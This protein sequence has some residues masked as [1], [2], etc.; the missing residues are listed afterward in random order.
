M[1]LARK[2]LF[3]IPI[4]AVLLVLDLGMA[5]DESASEKQQ[6]P[7][8]VLQNAT[9]HTMTGKG[10]FIGS[11]I[12]EDGK[13]KSVGKTVEIP[14]GAKVLDLKGHHI[15]PGLIETRSKLWL[16]SAATTET[17]T[18]ATLDVVDAIDP[19]SEDW[20]ELASQGITSVY[21]QPSSD[22]FLGGYGAVLRVGPFDSPEGIVLK[23]QVAIQASIGSKGATSKDRF[24]QVQSLEKLFESAKEK[25]K[26]E[27]SG[28]KKDAT[29]KAT[30]PNKDAE[31]ESAEGANDNDEKKDAKSDAEKKDEKE[32]PET[33]PTKL[34]LRRVLNKEIPLHIEIHH[35]DVL[36]Q[37][38]ALAEKLD[39]LIVLDGL[40]HVESLSDQ[41]KESG[42]PLVV[43]PMY[44]PGPVPDYRKQANF[45]W[46]A[47]V[48]DSG[49]LW[50]LSSFGTSGRS[51]RL[52]RA[53][54]AVAIRTGLDHQRV[55]ASVTSNPARMLG[56]VDQIG[57]L[58]TGKSADI[59]V[60]AGD[61][62]DPCTATRLVMSQGMITFENESLPME[63]ATTQAIALPQRLPAEYAIKSSR[64]LKDG[65]FVDGVLHINDG[66]IVSMAKN[67]KLEKIQ[68]FDL[69]DTIVTPGLVIA[70]STLGQSDSISDPTE[71]DASHLRS[72]DAV[73]PTSETA[74]KALAGGFIHVGLSPGTS[75]TSAGVVGH[76]RLG[77]V[78]Y[79]AEPA[80]ASQFVLSDSARQS[81]RFPSSLNGQVQMLTD[82]LK[83]RPAP[84][85]VYVSSAIGRSIAQEKTANIEAITKGQRP[86]VMVANSKLEI[87]SALA[88][89]KA[90]GISGVLKSTGRV[91][92]F[93]DQ[94]AQSKFGLIVPELKG[95]EYN[96]ALEQILAVG[97][98]GVPIGFSGDS[99]EKIRLTAAML[100]NAG[101]PPQT[102]LSGL[103]EGGGE[104]VGLKQT[105]F[106]T[107][108][109]AD[110]VVWSTSPLNLAAKP[111]NVVVDGQPITKK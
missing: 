99:A 105:G 9:I 77:A 36:K 47:D 60:F 55:L 103:T 31:S 62:L 82:L 20:Q 53:Q 88:L 76:L 27:P 14:D 41:I 97:K 84:S 68:V 13:I 51:S 83:G 15:I 69:Q 86:A 108:A 72:I 8:L 58:E 23:D 45:D 37:I 7:P 89:A 44:E 100:V 25:K 107:G 98:A 106:E 61:P 56:V 50:G 28:E 2:I 17:N 26:P 87:R 104:L 54:A 80:V 40:S 30:T 81:D 46:L 64:L 29:K 90:N 21:V 71:S 96:A 75:V 6:S 74:E 48:V 110:L 70:N 94:L 33:D 91:G 1:Q 19:W 65:K 12:V 3:G 24:A 78:D 73:D 32:K 18:K 92:E 5:Q 11:L 49:Q 101:L 38:L 10:S 4:V 109:P 42:H 79:V 63:V 34:A 67:A 111:L 95:D 52:L 22:S 43:G 35:T 39:I 93:A 85:S 66:K 57:T 102:A 59:A 16:T